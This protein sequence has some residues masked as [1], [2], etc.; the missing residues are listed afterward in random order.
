MEGE[1]IMGSRKRIIYF[2][3]M[4]LLKYQ[5]NV[6]PFRPMPVDDKGTSS[7]INT[8]TGETVQLYYSNAGVLTIDAGQAAGTVVIGQLAFDNIKNSIGAFEATKNDTSL[9]FTAGALTTE[10]Q[11][12]WEIFENLDETTLANRL[13]T[14]GALLSNGQYTVNYS[15]G[16]IY[17][18]KTTT[19]ATLA[20]TTYKYKSTSTAGAG[21]ITSI[22]PGTGATNLGK[23]EDAP[24]TSGDVGI[25]GLGVRQDTPVALAG[26]VGDYQPAIYDGNG[27]EW[28]TLGTKVAG[29]DL[30]ADV[31]KVEQRNNYTYIVTATT[32]VVKT[33]AGLL[34]TITVEGGTTGTIIV[35]D[36]TAASGTII[37]SFST[38]NA[39]ATYTFD[40]S[41]ATGC[42]VV[43][44]AATQLTISVR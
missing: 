37:A 33:G 20:A 6:S 19:A 34:H 28:T 16:T 13:T 39:M 30:T 29:E 25:M 12:D 40:V 32:T 3:Y 21:S 35:Y 44:S 4:S 5:A 17:G 43:T 38:T 9:S 22:I 7:A 27:N 36:N 2:I 41:F 14:I 11:I 31:L 10:V 8:I 18:K 23:A 1:R 15:D 42:T 26:T 24:H